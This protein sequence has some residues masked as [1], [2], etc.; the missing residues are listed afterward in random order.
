MKS[1][2]MNWRQELPQVKKVG[3]NFVFSP[4]GGGIDVKELFQKARSHAENSRGP[5]EGRLASAPWA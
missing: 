4:E 2:S 3:K 1:C 5:A